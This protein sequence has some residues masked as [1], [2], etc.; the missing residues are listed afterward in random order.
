MLMFLVLFLFCIL[1]NVPLFPSTDSLIYIPKHNASNPVAIGRKLLRT[2]VCVG[3]L[4]TST[5]TTMSG[6]IVVWSIVTCLRYIYSPYIPCHMPISPSGYGHQ[7]NND[8][9]YSSLLPGN[10]SVSARTMRCFPQS[11]HAAGNCKVTS[12]TIYLLFNIT[13]IQWWGWQ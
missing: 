7:T 3:W 1:I 13:I 12:H 8:L 5:Y 9:A 6:I 11:P 4:L 10:A 2:K